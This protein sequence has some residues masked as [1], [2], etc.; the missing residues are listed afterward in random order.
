VGIACRLAAIVSTS[1]KRP[2]M[3]TNRNS[4]PWN[5]CHIRDANNYIN[6]C[7]TTVPSFITSHHITSHQIYLFMCLS[8][9]SF[10]CSFTSISFYI[11]MLLLVFLDAACLILSRLK[12]IFRELLCKLRENFNRFH[13]QAFSLTHCSGT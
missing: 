7:V 13:K 4:F 2:P 8:L 3:L 10:S 5:P 9:S 6:L 11:L 12:N 1:N